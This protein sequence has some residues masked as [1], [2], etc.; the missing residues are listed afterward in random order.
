MFFAFGLE[1]S[2]EEEQKPVTQQ[3]LDEDANV[4]WKLG[5]A[6]D[7]K[8]QYK[9]VL[10]A[11]K[12]SCSQLHKCGA[13][14]GFMHAP[15]V[16][17]C[18]MQ[19]LDVEFKIKASAFQ[20]TGAIGLDDQTRFNIGKW[21]R[22]IG[23]HHD[24]DCQNIGWTSQILCHATIEDCLL[25]PKAI[26]SAVAKHQQNYEEAQKL[27]QKRVEL[28]LEWETYREDQMKL[29]NSKSDH[30]LPQNQDLTVWKAGTA[31]HG[32]RVPHPR[33]T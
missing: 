17:P 27:K 31:G 13:C 33:R 30:V 5:V 22:G 7:E 15:F 1:M 12:V 2:K 23:M 20:P 6:L 10:I 14:P 16:K 9:L 4:C 3:S 26:F 32:T 8:N 21:N 19:W 24:D 28:L 25:R 29:D 11:L 18:A